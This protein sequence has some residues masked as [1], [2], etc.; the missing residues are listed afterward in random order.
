[1]VTRPYQR[2]KQNPRFLFGVGYT[3]LIGVILY[4]LLIWVFRWLGV[5]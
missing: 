5:W 4:D 2:R 3:V 1:M